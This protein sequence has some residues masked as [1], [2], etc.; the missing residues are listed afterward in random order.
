M[1]CVCALFGE[2]PVAGLTDG[3]VPRRLGP[4]RAS[5]IR[6]LFNL[7]KDDDVRKYVISR[8]YVNKKGA[9]RRKAPKIQR[10]VT[11]IML[12]RKRA[13]KAKKLTAVK[14]TQ[15]DAA[16]YKK[17]VMQRLAEKKDARR[18][19]LSKRRSSR[20]SAKLAA[21]AAPKKE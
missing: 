11:P 16:T 10:L 17:L 4:K 15:A 2:S 5:N 7:G 9:T 13:R 8:T 1:V 12:Q 14:N 19:M 3:S 6:K 18:S 20:R 21:D